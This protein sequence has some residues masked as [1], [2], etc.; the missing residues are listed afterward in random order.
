[1]K[2]VFTKIAGLSVGLAMAIGVGVAVG[3][4]EAKVVKAE[5]V[6]YNSIGTGVAG[7]ETVGSNEVDKITWTLGGGI[8]AIQHKGDATSA[9]NTAYNTAS[10]IRFYVKHVFSFEAASGYSIVGI[11]FTNSGNASYSGGNLVASTTWAGGASHV[12][13]SDTTNLTITG[14]NLPKGGETSI[15]AKSGSVSAIYFSVDKQT[16]P[17]SFTISYIK[18]DAGAPESI[19]CSAQTLSVT[20]TVLLENEVTFTPNG[21]SCDI[22]YSIESGS[23]CIDLSETG[24]ITGKKSGSAV[25]IITPEDTS[26]GATPI[27]VSV[28]INPISAPGISV[29]EKYVLYAAD[30]ADSYNGELTGV[31]SSKGTVAQFT[32]SVPSCTYILD[33]EAGYFENT[34][35]LKNGSTYLAYN[36]G[37]SSN[38]LHTSNSVNQGS[39][40]I[41]SWDSGTN[42]AV[43]TN[44]G[45]TTRSLQF[46]YNKG[47]PLFACYAS[48]QKLVSLYHYS[49]KALNDFSIDSEIS[50]YV[51]GTQQ[52]G[53]RY[54][55]ADA[56]DKEL[57][58]TSANE[59]IATV[60]ENGLV[61]GVAVG[62]VIITASKTIKGSLVERHCTVTVLNNVSAHR[63]T[64]VD[65]F[66]VADAVEVAKG[67][68]TKDP[69]GNPISLAN[70]YHVKGLVTAVVNRTTS[71]LT[72]WIGDNDSQTSADKGA[73][74]VFKVKS[75]Y[76]V[77][78]GTAYSDNSEV[79][80]DF[81]VGYHVIV[82]STFIYYSET[83]PETEQN[84]ADIVYSDYIEARK[85]ADAFN[86]AFEAEGVCDAEGESVVE[87]LASVWSEQSIAYS[88]LDSD[89]KSILASTEGSTKSSAT[90]VE[91]CAA[92][93]DYIGG[94]Y[95]TQLG[96]EY[97]FMG[98]NPSPISGGTIQRFDMATE[99]NNTMIIVISIAAVSALAFATLLVFKKKK[100]K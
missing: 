33:V 58:W 84:K 83:T 17:A 8:T 38:A 94:K 74:E 15:V 3:S 86:V 21:S 68:F 45:T 98:R 78:L 100:Q 63:G 90:D 27:N 50:V 32:G 34:V 11:K 41:V 46:N 61:T 81:A 9:V 25:V 39:S 37:S 30:E 89:A 28:T 16:R 2:K 18:P 49:E 6:D 20:N 70:E 31:A 24:V 87:T 4:K 67:I 48:E 69:D 80:R 10:T 29:G 92:K 52:I 65:P 26:G 60:N 12:T 36:V 77:A 71:T 56:S 91:K 47:T 40:W 59:G 73:F 55:P 7:K 64:A 72:F 62:E 99:D 42:A 43:L 82:K 96:A 93:Y 19:S 75:V 54:D 5:T 44:A 53:V 66:D 13:T 97:D 79:V 51:S 14:A 1:M 85:Y 22:S 76:G 35:A 23:D 95:Q 88:A 57:S